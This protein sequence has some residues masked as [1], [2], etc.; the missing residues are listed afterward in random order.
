MDE[1]ITMQGC[2]RSQRDV[3]QEILTDSEERASELR[4]GI[5]LAYA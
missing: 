3:A 5:K 4:V 1:H 2:T